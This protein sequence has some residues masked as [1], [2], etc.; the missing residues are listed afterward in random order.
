MDERQ[1]RIRE[2]A[3]LEESRLNQEFIEFLQKWSMPLLVVIAAVAV[4]YAAW[5]KFK[6][7]RVDKTNAAFHDLEA[8]SATNNPS[9]ESLKRVADDYEGVASVS[10]LARLAAAEQYMRTVRSGVKPGVE[11]MPD[12]T[13]AKPDDALS[14]QDTAFSLAQAKSLYQKIYDDTAPAP[15]K[16]LL[17]IS[18]LYGLAAVAEAKK[19][20]TEAQ[21]LYLKLADLADKSAYPAHSSIARTRITQLDQIAKDIP[22]YDRA[23]LPTMPWE[24]VGPP[25]PPDPAPQPPALEGQGPPAP[26]D[27]PLTTPATTPPQPTPDQPTPTPTTPIPAPTPPAV[28][29]ADPPPPK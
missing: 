26:T 11:L 5:G 6:Q 19:D 22:L 21:S 16:E 23:D 28:P 13:F 4:G 2:G 9:P 29:P 14:D 10:H 3:G 1:Q 25:A 17:T 24:L 7:A 15:G 8:A 12:G 20:S 18:A 27:T